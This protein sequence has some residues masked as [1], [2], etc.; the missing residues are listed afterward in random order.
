METNDLDLIIGLTIILGIFWILISL[1][2]VIG[3]VTLS[4]QTLALRRSIISISF[5]LLIVEIYDVQFN[6]EFL[7]TDMPDPQVASVL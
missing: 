4:P 3:K 2:L 1:Y 6:I 5:V 7:K